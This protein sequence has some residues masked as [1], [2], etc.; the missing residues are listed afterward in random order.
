MRGSIDDDGDGENHIL[1]FNL[2]RDNAEAHLV[3]KHIV[4]QLVSLE[5]ELLEE[6]ILPTLSFDE[7]RTV[8]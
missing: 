7:N 2:V 5:Y 3:L 8:A 4:K 1:G 6:V